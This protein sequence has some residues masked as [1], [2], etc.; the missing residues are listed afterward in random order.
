MEINVVN[1]ALDVQIRK[2]GAEAVFDQLSARAE[3]A[4]AT[5]IKNNA[6]E[7]SGPWHVYEHILHLMEYVLE[8]A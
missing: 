4:K 5:A 8:H 3:L 1:W 2:D 7:G 6:P